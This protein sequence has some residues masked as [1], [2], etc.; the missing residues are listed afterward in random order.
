MT[1][2]L[3]EK[4]DRTVTITLNRPEKLNAY[5]AQDIQEL[6]K[7]WYKF[8]DDPDAWTAILTGAGKAFCAGH[9]LASLPELCE[10]EPPSIHYR[11]L[12]LF[13]PIICAVNGHALGGGCS[14][15]MGCDIR[16]AAENATF[17]Y[18][19]PNYALT[20]LGGHQWMPRMTFRGIAMEMMLTGDRITAQEAYRIGLVN[21]VV[22]LDQLMPTALKL[23]ERINANGPL[24]VRATKEDFLVGERMLW[25]PDGTNFSRLNYA[26]LWYTSEDV[27]EGLKAFQEKR[28]PVYKG[29]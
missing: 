16:I 18:P 20:S 19:Q 8:R 15:T 25:Q 23:A 3:Y 21:K 28:K 24:A 4:K 1:Y 2:V 6:E 9:D 27:K 11:N 22:P 26:K 10:P 13:K 7:A 17:G 29:K 14:M 12:E 5:T